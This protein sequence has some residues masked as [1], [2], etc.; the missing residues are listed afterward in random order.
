[1]DR[2]DSDDSVEE[3]MRDRRYLTEHRQELTRAAQDLYPGL[4]R[5]ADTPLLT[6]PE[7]LPEGPVPL[8]RVALSLRERSD[9]TTTGPADRASYCP[10]RSD[11]TRY[12]SYAAALA[13]LSRPKLFENRICYRLLAADAGTLTFGLGRYFDLINTCEAV[14]HEYAAAKLN[15]GDAGHPPQQLPLREEIGD[16][17]D[18]GRRPVMAAISALVLIRGAA[19]AEMILH[20]RDPAKVAT[21]GGQ[22]TTAPV[23]IFQPSH[24]APWNLRNDFGLWRS[25]VR[26]LNEEVLDAGEDYGSD[27]EPID[28]QRWPVYRR[29]TDSVQNVRW[30]GMGVDPLSLVLD[31]LVVAVFDEP[32]APGQDRANAE[33]RLTSAVFNEQNVR[34]LTSEDAQPASA[35]LLRLAWRHRDTIIG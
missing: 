27:K 22:L 4:P 12:A 20:R 8:D 28:Y 9:V 6:R 21:G 3:W 19:G 26:E 17:T 29:L 34:R 7:W 18:L 11:G 14:A 16:P 23:G 31:M 10:L 5:V 24:D 32:L 2:V 25:L 35:A 33:G 1:V 13:E 15:T 30:L